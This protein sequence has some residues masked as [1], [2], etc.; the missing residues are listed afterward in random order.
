MED[1]R[2]WEFERSLWTA[3]PEHYQNSIDDQCVMAL[4]APPF[5]FTGQQSIEAVSNTP[6]W[7]QVEL[8]DRQVARLQEGLIVIGYTAHA[9]RGEERYTAHCTSTY[10]RLGHE[11]WKVVQHSQVVALTS[12]GAS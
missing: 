11:N 3:S 10:R 8:T 6:R 12:H 1:A 9:E 4:P 5:I 2:I 7:Q